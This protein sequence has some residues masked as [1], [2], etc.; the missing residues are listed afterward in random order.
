MSTMETAIRRLLAEC[1]G[2]PG[3]TAEELS[4]RLGAPVAILRAE[5]SAL[6]FRKDGGVTC[7]AESKTS[8]GRYVLGDSSELRGTKTR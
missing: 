2:G 5:L 6:V 1:N 8:E 3:L 4:A 7:K